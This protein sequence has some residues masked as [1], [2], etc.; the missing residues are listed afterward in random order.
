MNN[1]WKRTLTG[2]VFIFAII[3]SIVF[4]PFVFGIVF[5]IISLLGL[6]E[7]QNIIRKSGGN[8]QVIN[9]FVGG[10]IIYVTGF[11][12]SYYGVDF[13]WFLLLVP[14]FI[15]IIS[16]ELFKGNTN[17]FENISL[18]VFSFVYTVIPFVF[19]VQL[20]FVE[21]GVY[22]CHLPLV[23][24]LMIWMN[25]TGAYLVGVS[26]GKRRL[27]PRISPKKS[28]EGF[29]GGVV[30]TLF[31]GVVLSQFISVISLFDFI[32]AGLIISVLGTWGDLTESMLKRSKGIKDSS[33]LLPGHGGIL[34][35]FDALTFAAPMVY[36]YFEFFK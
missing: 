11:L 10:L 20:G 23:F 35:R 31:L 4:H 26:F 36:I 30:L 19:L 21:N 16:V 22:N 27:F 9:S 8:I 15:S 2:I 33:D 32:V 14:V 5:L 3:C 17:P 7:Y 29:V 13:K 34:D 24:F 1:F 28:W 12:V 25:D 18:T 6:F